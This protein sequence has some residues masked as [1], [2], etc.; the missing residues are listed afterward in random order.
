[1]LR[2]SPPRQSDGAHYV[3]VTDPGTSL[4]SLATDNGFRRVFH[5]DPDIGG[6]YSALSAFGLV[7]AA[8]AG[9]DVGAVLD[10]AIAAA[11]ECRS[12][13]GNPGLWLGAAL[14]ELARQGRDKLTF[15]VDS[16]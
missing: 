15:V 10:S 3:A 7:P 6:R 2:P 16:P 5:G 9:I 8:L 13:Q 12:E 11:E 1:M 14:G 4:E